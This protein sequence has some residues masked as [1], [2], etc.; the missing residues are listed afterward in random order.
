MNS[1]AVPGLVIADPTSLILLDMHMPDPSGLEVMR[2][3]HGTEGTH[4]IPVIAFSGDQ[5]Y[6]TVS[7]AA[8]AAAFL[9]KPFSHDELETTILN[10]LSSV[11]PPVA[12]HT[13]DVQDS[14]G[15]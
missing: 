15:A 9:I 11:L 14:L 8:G 7:G 3:L 13:A 10:A 4:R 5:R 6:R 1:R 12:R 2:N